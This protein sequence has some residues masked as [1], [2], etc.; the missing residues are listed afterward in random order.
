M[1]ATETICRFAL[2]LLLALAACAPSREPLRKDDPWLNLRANALYERAEEY[3]NSGRYAQAMVDY[4]SYLDQYIDLYRANDSAF[5][6]AQCLEGLGERM[7]A[8]D[9]YRATGIVFSRS[10]LAP[11][12]HL[13]AGEL[14]ELEG[15]LREAKF[16]YEK[17]VEYHATEPGRLALGRLE[18]VRQRIAVLEAERATRRREGRLAAGGIDPALDRHRR[19]TNERTALDILL[20]R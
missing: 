15:W 11:S 17:A 7:E 19:V 3:Y 16:D 2:L 1:R 6:I 18:E 5:R 20:S 10:G 9:A 12:A 8:A 14:F 13:R 4:R